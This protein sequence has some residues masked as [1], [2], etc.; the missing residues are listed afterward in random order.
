MVTNKQTAYT[1]DEAIKKIIQKEID[2]VIYHTIGNDVKNLEP[3]KCVD[4]IEAIVQQNK[5]QNPERKIILSLGIRRKD[6]A[7][8]N[9]RTEAVNSLLKSKYLED[10]MVKCCHHNNIHEISK[11]G[12]RLI[13]EDGVH[14]T[15]DGT[16]LFASNLRYAV[17]TCLGLPHRDRRQ[18]E[19]K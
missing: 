1:A 15:N 6:S 18:N 17:E 2:C 11:R 5:V 12:N 7:V 16:S 9:A 3:T 4:K 14:L 19:E 13:S 10:R 8:F